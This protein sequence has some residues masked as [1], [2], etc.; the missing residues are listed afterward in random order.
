[1]GQLP[2]CSHFQ[3]GDNSISLTD[4]K[5]PV[6]DLQKN[7]DFLLLSPVLLAQYVFVQ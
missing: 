5:L 7:S 3:N 6:F 2:L 4:L 1:M